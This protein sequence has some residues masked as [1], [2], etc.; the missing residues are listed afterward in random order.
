L[1]QLDVAVCSM[2]TSQQE[3]N[4]FMNILESDGQHE[5]RYLKP[6]V[7]EF[8]QTQTQQVCNAINHGGY[9]DAATE[10]HD[11]P[12]NQYWSFKAYTRRCIGTKRTCLLST[13]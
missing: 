3:I 7:N 9:F 4:D 13:G 12:Y 2:T 11:L 6:L 10:A 8:I 1:Y 5:A